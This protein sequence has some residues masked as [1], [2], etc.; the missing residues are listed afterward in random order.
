MGIKRFTGSSH[1]L[2]SPV[3]FSV[4][5]GTIKI[6]NAQFLCLPTKRPQA[7]KWRIKLE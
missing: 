1:Q 5:L 3:V 2:R 6:F 4:S 7:R